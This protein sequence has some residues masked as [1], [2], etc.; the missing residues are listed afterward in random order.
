M[1]QTP[2]DVFHWGFSSMKISR[3]SE[4]YR[5]LA[6][7]A[8]ALV[9][10]LLISACGG[11]AGGD[12]RTVQEPPI[13]NV[14]GPGQFKDAV[15]L[16]T[17]TTTEIAAAMEL[18]GATAFRASPRYAVQAYRLTYLTLDGQGREILASALVVLP[19]KPANSLSPVL[20]YQHAT[21]RRQ[22]EAPSNLAD[23]GSPEVVLASLGYIVLSA[24]YVGYGVSKEAS[25]PYMLSGPSASAVID[26]LTAAKYWRQTQHVLDN[27][28]LFLAGY[29]EGA[30]VT[31][32]TQRALQA[33]ASTHRH[34][35]VSVA[36]GAG[37]Y[38]VGLTLDEELKI[39]RQE[40]PLLGAL[41]SPGFL[42]YLSDADRHNVRDLLLQQV[43]GADTDVTF[44]PTVLDNYLVDDRSSIEILSDVYDWRAEVP[45]NLFHGRAD[46]TVSYLNASSALQAMQARGSGNLVTLT[47]CAA[48]PAG[49]LECVL[50]HWRFMLETFTK[51]AKDL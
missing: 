33:G 18:A 36:P 4:S 21:L 12:A 11:G 35:V 2:D 28:Q 7:A 6:R 40:Y 25:H 46:L 49:H 16:R 24:D 8:C 9:G 43:L 39:V 42:K 32:A 48:Q 23:L 14:I 13:V 15:N 38:N 3:T 37:P 1:G 17:I 44:M 31:L 29:S 19:Q 50:P 34:E 26:M 45:V 5:Q 51:V 22:A 47:D 10:V 30:Y 41:L 27:K 20:S